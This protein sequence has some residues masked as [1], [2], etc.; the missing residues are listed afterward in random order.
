MRLCKQAN[1]DGKLTDDERKKARQLALQLAVD[2]AK[3]EGWDPLVYYSGPV[4]EGLIERFVRKAKAENAV[5][6]GEKEPRAG[7]ASR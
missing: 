1:E 6:E 7:H 3:D 5:A 2:I 4:I